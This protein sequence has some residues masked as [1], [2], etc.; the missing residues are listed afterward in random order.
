V[1]NVIQSGNPFHEWNL[2]DQYSWDIKDFPSGL[3]LRNKIRI[4]ILKSC[5]SR[6][7]HRWYYCVAV[8]DIIRVIELSTF[9]F[10]NSL[11]SSSNS[12]W[13][14]TKNPKIVQSVLKSIF[15]NQKN[16][17]Q[18]SRFIFGKKTKF[19]YR[20]SHLLFICPKLFENKIKIL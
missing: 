10:L 2:F 14:K 19:Q 18:K 1:S 12:N 13:H 6:R 16:P 20:I 9:S 15:F 5:W 8:C 17:P 7:R 3:L 4:W 11:N